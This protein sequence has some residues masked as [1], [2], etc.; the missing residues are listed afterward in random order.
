MSQITS[1]VYRPE[2]LIALIRKSNLV[3]E[4]RLQTFL[5]SLE[6]QGVVPSSVKELGDRLIAAGVLTP[7]Q[8]NQ[9]MRGKWKG[10]VI[11]GKYRLL[12][13]LGAGG[14]GRVFLC[15]HIRMRRLVALKMLPDHQVTTPGAIERFDREARAVAALNHPNIVQAYDVDQDGKAHFLVMEHVEGITL[16]ELVRKIGPLHPVRAANYIAQC[17]LGLQHAYE[18][19]GLIHRD[20]K[21]ANLL[22]DRAGNIKILDMGLARFFHDHNDALTQKYDEKNILGTADYISPEQALDSHGVD[23]RADIYSLGATLYYLLTGGPP[24]PDGSV[25]QKLM[26]HQ[27]KEP[28]PVEAVR[29]EVPPEMGRIV[30]KMMAKDREARFQSH[31]EV[32][33]ALEFWAHQPI[34]PPAESEMPQRQLAAYLAAR[35]TASGRVKQSMFLKA[36]TGLSGV[37]SA[38]PSSGRL[39]VM[40]PPASGTFPAA[41]SLSSS[42]L[43]A[44]SAMPT[45]RPQQTLP[46]HVPPPASSE[47][48]ASASSP[49]LASA[50]TTAPAPAPVSV[51]APQPSS[52]PMWIGVAVGV[53]G[54]LASLWIV[55]HR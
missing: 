22:L 19:A 26:W 25:P 5:Q 29:P 14:M 4:P 45:P 42:Q 24:F 37:S 31:L 28:L 54:V 2:D 9:L 30:Q 41:A 8:V 51:A 34:D 38:G 50:P 53:L 10:F 43:P 15:E 1:A 21:P 49:S 27:M 39:P 46:N 18:A 44:S 48:S 3:D 20:I 32:A 23:H 7:F 33:M 16:E 40:T 55:T 47:T 52:L 11:S 6:A 35:E 36:R 13:L 17:A 12:D